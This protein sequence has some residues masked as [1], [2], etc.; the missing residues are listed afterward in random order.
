MYRTRLVI[1]SGVPCSGVGTTLKLIESRGFPVDYEV[2]RGLLEE[3]RAKGLD[4]RKRRMEDEPGFQRLVLYL[5]I[6]L[7]R[8][9]PGFSD[10]QFRFRERGIL[11][12]LQ[13]FRNCGL[14][15]NEASGFAD[16][17][18][19]WI[20]LWFPQLIWVPEDVRTETEEARE[21]LKGIRKD[22]EDRGIRVIELAKTDSAEAIADHILGELQK[23]L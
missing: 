11:D 10:A 17:E 9:S 23:L 1:C 6:V 3:W 21:A 15:P 22:Y 5:K 14:D 16:E 4:P 18:R 2:A 7:A 19:P 8:R 13:Y 20:V 12:S